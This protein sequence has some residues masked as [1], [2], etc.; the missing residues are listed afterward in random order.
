M[1]T[2]T[3]IMNYAHYWPIIIVLIASTAIVYSGFDIFQL[4]MSAIVSITSMVCITIF[5][6]ISAIVIR[7]IVYFLYAMYI[8]LTVPTFIIHPIEGVN[9]I[10]TR[11]DNDDES[12]EITTADKDTSTEESI[13]V[14]ISASSSNSDD[15]GNES[16]SDKSPSTEVAS[17]AC[18]GIPMGSAESPAQLRSRPTELEIPETPTTGN[19]KPKKWVSKHEKF[20][21][22]REQ[23]Q[24]ITRQRL[25]DTRPEFTPEPQL[26]CD[27]DKSSTEICD[28]QQRYLTEI[29]N[30]RTALRAMLR[31]KNSLN[32]KAQSNATPVSKEVAKRIELYLD[33]TRPVSDLD[34]RANEFTPA[35]PKR[36]DNPDWRKFKTPASATSDV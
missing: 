19:Y 9:P 32:G 22:I 23:E 21:Q 7:M 25:F 24:R 17:T 14:N 2:T 6:G 3:E 11:Q 16:I 26:E 28:A 5:A 36:S 29:N 27:C 1:I 13:V 31:N 15:S 33:N 18:S 10:N 34:P 12:T 35:T 4:L 30:R 20:R 8:H